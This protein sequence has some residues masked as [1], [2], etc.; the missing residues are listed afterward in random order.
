M[1]IKQYHLHLTDNKL[2]NIFNTNNFKK[3]KLTNQP[4]QKKKASIYVYLQTAT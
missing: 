2:T 3:Y 1:Q 4:L